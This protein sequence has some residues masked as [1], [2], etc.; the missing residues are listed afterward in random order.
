MA[1]STCT[2]CR[3]VVPSG[4]LR[5]PSCGHEVASSGTKFNAAAL[6]PT[7]RTVGIA[8]FVLFVSII[9]LPWF[10]LLG[11]TGGA[12]TVHGYLYLTLFVSIGILSLIGGQAFGVIKMPEGTSVS[13]DQML[14]LGAIVNFVFVLL[15]FLLK[16]SGYLTYG[17]SRDYGAYIG[18]VAAIVALAALGLP[19]I[20]SRRAK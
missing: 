20:R 19:L 2:N 3:G 1:T 10:S 9:F 11:H 13:H 18:L 14:T 7:D 8:T 5:C 12:L 4:A 15:G 16:P 17:V 6:S